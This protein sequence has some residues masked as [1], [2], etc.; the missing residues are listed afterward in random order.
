ME[1]LEELDEELDETIE[2]L[3]AQI[4]AN[5]ASSRNQRLERGMQ[6]SL[7]EYFKEVSDAIGWDTLQQIYYR[8]VEQ[9]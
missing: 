9:R 2:L 3:E 1:T 7:A 4:P 8:Y 5:P 6:N